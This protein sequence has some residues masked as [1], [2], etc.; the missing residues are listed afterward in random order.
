ML[1]QQDLMAELDALIKA[2]KV[3]RAGLYAGPEVVAEAM[4]SGPSTL[5]AMQFGANPFT[6]L[7]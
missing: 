6:T 2:G 3:L 4:A 1:Q 5:N 7:S